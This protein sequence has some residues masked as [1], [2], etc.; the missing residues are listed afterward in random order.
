MSPLK[1]DRPAQTHCCE[2]PEFV[3]MLKSSICVVVILV[4]V[5]CGL[6]SDPIRMQSVAS[7]DGAFTADYYQQS[8]GGATG[9]A[10]DVVSI[11]PS[12][13]PFREKLDRVFGAIDARDVKLRW[14]ASRR[15]EI[16]YTKKS[17]APSTAKASWRE[18]FVDY[19]VRE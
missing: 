1:S 10:A 14:T 15:L 2:R 5:S 16:T 8:G 7:P 9:G 12:N 3:E 4:L 13:E 11:R 19:V 17:I 18:V 6:A